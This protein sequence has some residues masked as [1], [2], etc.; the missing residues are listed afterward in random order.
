VSVYNPFVNISLRFPAA[1]FDDIKVYCQ[2]GAR[3][4]ANGRADP[5]NSPFPRYVDF[6]FLALCLG[7]SQ[8]SR[9]PDPPANGWRDF[10]TG[11]EGFASD[12]WRVDV[13]ELIAIAVHEDEGVIG[14]PGEVLDAANRLAAAGVPQ[15]LDWLTSGQSDAIDNL[16]DRLRDQLAGRP[17]LSA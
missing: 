17:P 11:S 10:I 9:L 15:V 4:E 7:A 1:Y 5:C 6:W 13:V 8:Y 16:L 2:T 3:G 14:R 12:P